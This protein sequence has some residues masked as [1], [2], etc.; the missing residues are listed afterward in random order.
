VPAVR[1]VLARYGDTLRSET[2]TVDLRVVAMGEWDEVVDGLSSVTF[3]LDGQEVRAA[4]EA[5]TRTG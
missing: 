1:S 5:R 2:L 3:E 4:L